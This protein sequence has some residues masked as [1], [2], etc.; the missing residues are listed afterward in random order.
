V[1]VPSTTAI[2]KDVLLVDDFHRTE[3]ISLRIEV[4]R[5]TF[6]VDCDEV[7]KAVDTLELWSRVGAFSPLLPGSVAGRSFH[8]MEGSCCGSA[9]RASAEV[10]QH[11]GLPLVG[12][13]GEP[14]AASRCMKR[15]IL[16]VDDEDGA[17]AGMRRYFEHGGY[18]VDCAREKEEAEA[19]LGHLRYDCVIAD[20]CLTAGRGPDGLEII[21]QA[22]CWR[23][24]TPVVVLTAEGSPQVEATAVRLGANA[25][26]HK[27]IP[28][29]DV[30]SVVARIVGDAT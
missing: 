10:E 15:R 30:A 9:S 21:E 11:D 13:P 18:Q 14:L 29:G 3:E 16:I 5:P 6:D 8:E 23:P 4:S 27:P 20:L 1:T 25:F 28:L 22:R 17:L 7:T 12:R 24:D 26:L 2:C 19:L